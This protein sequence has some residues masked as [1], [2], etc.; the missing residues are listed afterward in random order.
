MGF[1]QLPDRLGTVFAVHIVVKKVSIEKIPVFPPAAVQ[2][3]G[4][5]APFYKRSRSHFNEAK[6]EVIRKS[7][8]F[9]I[10]LCPGMAAVNYNLT[11]LTLLAGI[12]CYS[13]MEFLRLSGVTVPLV[14][15]LTGLSSRPRD[16]GRFVMGP[17]TL[18]TGALLALLLFP[19]QVAGIAIFAL[20]FGDGFAG[21]AGKLFGRHR[22]AFLFGKSVEGSL[23]CFAAT[24]FCAF[25]V[26]NNHTV[27][28]A[29]AI[30]AA[31]VEALPLED[32]DNI[33][34]PLVVGLTVQLAMK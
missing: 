24:Y 15:V 30:T 26:S 13:V 23:A 29:A 19:P 33:L 27:S 14:S 21:L 11:V 3:P 8:H 2:F 34:L 1:F 22:P 12:L 5:A 16:I 7:I 31:A 25:M 17:V 4:S 32:Y 6:T 18:G 20:A 28:V 10:A 9:L